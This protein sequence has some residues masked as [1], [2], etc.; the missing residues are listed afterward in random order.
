MSTM[1]PMLVNFEECPDDALEALL[2]LSGVREQ[3]NKELTARWQKAYYEA[4]LTGRLDPALALGLHSR[5]KV[6]AYTRAENEARGRS[7][8]RWQ[9]SR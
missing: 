2:W 7:V 1:Q 6:M 8:S 4:R 3:V 9:D 5:K